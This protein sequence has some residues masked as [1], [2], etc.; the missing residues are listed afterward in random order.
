MPDK[1][2]PDFLRGVF[3]GDGYS[4][5]YW[6]KRWASSF[7]F[8]ICFTSASRDF[9]EWLRRKLQKQLGINGHITSQGRNKSCLQLKYAKKE[10]VI[11]K[12]YM[13]YRN[14][15]FFFQENS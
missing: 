15:V 13:Y 3:D 14:V 11:V 8:Y 1:Y 2:F 5:S 4:Y 6:D 7:M 10:A 9:I 12:K